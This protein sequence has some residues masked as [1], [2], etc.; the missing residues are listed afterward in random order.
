M[1]VLRRKSRGRIAVTSALCCGA[2]RVGAFEG[3]FVAWVL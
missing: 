2:E 3:D 1:E